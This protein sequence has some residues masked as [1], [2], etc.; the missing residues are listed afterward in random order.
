MLSSHALPDHLSS[1]KYIDIFFYYNIKL[2]LY[3]QNFKSD[4][5]II[6]II[7][8]FMNYNY[9]KVIHFAL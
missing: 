3:N 7:N 9:S 5:T 4:I 8:K 1:K 2:V 6:T